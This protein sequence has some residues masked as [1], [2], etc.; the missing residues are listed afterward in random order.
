MILN[1]LLM[2][3][4]GLALFLGIALTL[5]G[6]WRVSLGF[7]SLAFFFYSI[8]AQ[9]GEVI[10]SFLLTLILLGVGMRWQE[11]ADKKWA[12]KHEKW[13]AAKKIEDEENEKKWAIQKEAKEKNKREY[14]EKYGEKAWKLKRIH[15]SPFS[16][17]PEAAR[18]HLQRIK[19][20]EE[21]NYKIW[22]EKQQNPPTLPPTENH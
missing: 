19:E 13:Q 17:S 10:G 18:A 3:S 22:L 16:N 6:S 9:N 4:M 7:W 14:I 15:V 5:V 2:S 20:L 8:V 11:S 1:L 21:E 12:Q